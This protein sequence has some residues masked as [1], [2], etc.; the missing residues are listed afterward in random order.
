MLGLCL[1]VSTQCMSAQSGRENILTP[2]TAIDAPVVRTSNGAVRGVSD[3]AVST[4][5]GIP[6]AVPP[7]G[8]N[9]W[10][11]P[12]PLLPWQ[13]VRDA[14]K[15]GADCAQTAFRPGA[16]SMSPTSSEDCLYLN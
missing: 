2:N 11:P 14:S 15:F 1:L 8:D 7:V 13:G 10:R 3:G 5:K 9:R 12:Q 16:V 4:F 6:F